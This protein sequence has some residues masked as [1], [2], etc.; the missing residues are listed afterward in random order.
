MSTLDPFPTALGLAQQIRAGALSAAEALDACLER[1]DRL[2]PA[3][4]AV[5]WRDDER[6]RADAAAVDR[7]LAAARTGT[8]QDEPGPFAGVPVPVK[9]LAD[10]AGQPTT[11]GSAGAS[12]RVADEDELAVG[13]LRAAG[14]VLCGRTNAPEFGPL[15]VTENLR[16]GITRNPW[17]PSRTPGGSS[18]GAAVAVASGMVPVAHGSDGGGSIR[19]P[20]A[21]TGLVG[22]KPS[23]GRVPSATPGWLGLSVDGALCHTVADAAAILDCLSRPDPTVWLQAPAPERPFSEEPGAEPGKRRVALL[24]TSALG[25]GVDDACRAALDETGRTLEELGHHVSVL[26]EDVLDPSLAEPFLHLL[27][28]SYGAYEDI[29]WDRVEPH[30]AAARQAGLSTDSVTLVSAVQTL[31]TASRRIAARWGRDF[32]VLATPTV[33]IEPPAAGEVLAAAHADPG[34]PPLAVI[35]MIAFTITANF[36]GLPAI[37]LP[38]GVSPAGLPVGVQLVEGPF[39]EGPLLRLAAQ[40]E[41]AMPWAHRHPPEVVTAST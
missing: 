21:C 22:L 23:R 41:R 37:S 19:I 9:D 18:G 2:N 13:A 36:T 6:A 26:D 33:P 20:A 25:I 5:V 24:A 4:N 32:D 34:V 16:Y 40:L 28:A 38:L 39:A 29:D 27:N 12:G 31:F 1:I 11:W 7:R 3:L 10:A 14:F 35:A 15:P 17:D 30:N 8:G